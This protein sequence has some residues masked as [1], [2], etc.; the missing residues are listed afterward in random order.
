MELE[1][2]SVS[3]SGKSPHV[4][5]LVPMRRWF[6]S[7]P[8]CGVRVVVLMSLAS[9]SDV[10]ES[11][12]QASFEEPVDRLRAVAFS[13]DRRV[14]MPETGGAL[15][16]LGFV[17]LTVDQWLEVPVSGCGEAVVF[18]E[19]GVVRVGAE[20]WFAQTLHRR[21][22]T[23][24]VTAL[25]SASLVVAAVRAADPAP[26][27]C[28]AGEAD[29]QVADIPR[30]PFAGGKLQVR[31]LQDAGVGSALA[32][33]SILEAETGLSVPPHMHEASAEALVVTEGDGV[34]VQGETRTNVRAPVSFYVPKQ[35][36]HAYEAGEG[37]LRA[38]QFYAPPGPEQR[39]R[40]PPVDGRGAGPRPA[41]GS[42]P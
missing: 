32:A 26:E 14:G 9:C 25:E 42:A 10:S 38:V 28:P 35:T 15:V 17:T 34:M 7:T 41:S 13:D 16:Q 37:P 8:L 21:S 11:S 2:D 33:I 1:L 27:S 40:T 12:S 22:A 31:I 19:S 30:L 36:Q 18:V 29:V 24:R 20:R 3:G 6:A 23:L 4:H 39:F 5:G